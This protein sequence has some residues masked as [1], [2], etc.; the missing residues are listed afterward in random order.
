M[1]AYRSY[2]RAAA[3]AFLLVALYT[4]AVKLARGELADDWLHRLHVATGTLAFHAGWLAA[5]GASAKA[6]TVAV[7]LVYGVLGVAGWFVDGLL[8]S[9]SFRIPLAAADNVFHLALAAGAAVAL[10]AARRRKSERPAGDDMR[11]RGS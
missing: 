8:M 3:V 7:G 11:G 6:L 2:A 5:S 1:G 10:A 9:T 4:V